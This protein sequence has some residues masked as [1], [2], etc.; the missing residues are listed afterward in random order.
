MASLALVSKYG[1]PP[2][3]WQNAW[4]RFEGITRLPSSTSI[5]FPITTYA[6]QTLH[7]LQ[8]GGTHEWEILWVCGARL[9]QK[10]VPPAVQRLEALGVVDVVH[11]NAAVGAAVECHAQGLES[12]LASR[13]PQLYRLSL[14]R[15]V[16]LRGSDLHGDQAVVD[17]H[18]LGQ[19]VGAYGGLVACAELLVDLHWVRAVDWA[20]WRS[21][22]IGSSSSSCRLRCRR[23]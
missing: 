3:D 4:A 2:L 21:V 9:D 7:L 12:L 22:R 6:H 11:E 15:V 8:A 10:L 23:E 20:G 5:L 17:E 13:I 18:L 14:G 16:C 1:I 19:E